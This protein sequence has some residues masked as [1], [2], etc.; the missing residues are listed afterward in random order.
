MK[1]LERSYVKDL[2]NVAR[3][4]TSQDFLLNAMI[5]Q[6][7]EQVKQITRR[8]FDKK[9]RTE[10][11][12]S[13]DQFFNDPDPQFVYLNAPPLDL[14]VPPTVTW[15]PYEQHDTS[16]ISLDLTAT[17]PDFQ[18]VDEDALLIIRGASGLIANFPP[19]SQGVPLFQYAPRGFKVIYTG[20]YT[21]STKSGA[22]AASG[23]VVFTENP[24]SLDTLTL[25]VV[26]WTFVTGAPGAN[27]TQ[28]G[29]DVAATVAQLVLDLNGSV[30]AG[31]I[32]ATYGSAMTLGTTVDTLTVTFDNAGEAGNAYVLGSS[33]G[34]NGPDWVTLRNGTNQ[35]AD[36]P[37]DDFGVIQI[38][39]ALKI[40][41]ARKIV[42]D[43]RE[44]ES[45]ASPFG[46]AVGF[47]RPW[48]D[49]QRM[50][51]RPWTKK[52]VVW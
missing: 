28:I 15:A 41:L 44:G 6:I 34:A 19:F 37:I 39:E 51:L 14:A 22:T 30:V 3:T 24:A 1:L 17:P 25:N 40:I 42:D 8:E 46:R 7:S 31:L 23:N 50:M 49:E 27:E 26:T 33:N 43:I 35:D 13:Y 29:V 10:Y 16:G 11:H 38:P 32:V 52:D 9:S 48:T 45:K 47:L 36:D 4:D 18:I 21:T 12:R 5:E 2:S 20:G